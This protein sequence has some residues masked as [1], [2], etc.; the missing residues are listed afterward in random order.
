MKGEDA[1]ERG[2]QRQGKAGMAL[3]YL[4]QGGQEFL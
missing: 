4:G 1:R 3:E 2:G